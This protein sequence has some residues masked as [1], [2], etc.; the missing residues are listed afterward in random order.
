MCM[1][2]LDVLLLNVGP[3]ELVHEI[4]LRISFSFFGLDGCYDL[5][6]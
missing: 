5:I 6:S 3:V 1:M 2:S 4:V